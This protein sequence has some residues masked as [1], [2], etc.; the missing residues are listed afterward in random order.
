MVDQA[1]QYTITLDD[2]PMVGRIIQ[3][4]LGMRSVQFTSGESLLSEADNHKPTAVFIDIHLD[5]GVN[6]LQTIPVLKAKWPFCPIIVITSDPTDEAVNEALASGAD[7]FVRKPIRP[8]EL[9]ARLRTR[10][11]DHAEKEAKQVVHTGD[12]TVDQAHHLLRGPQG[13]RY[14]SSTEINLL[15]SLVQ[16]Q[17]TTVPRAQLKSRCWDQIAVSD[18]ALDRKVYE[19]RRALRDVGSKIEVGTSYGI[20][21]SLSVPETH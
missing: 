1:Q 8:K 7:D 11:M 4:T 20:G 5:S 12:I 14:L 17:G 10:L 3:K 2:D 19:V 13:D 6:G 9:T 15:L 18:N 21:F 16:A